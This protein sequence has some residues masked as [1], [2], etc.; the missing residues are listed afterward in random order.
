[1]K[2]QPGRPEV[3][4]IVTAHNMEDVIDEALSSLA[5]QTWPHFHVLVV[6]DGSTDAT[7]SRI[8]AWVDRD[9]RFSMISTPGLGAGEARNVGMSA[10]TA[11]YFM[12]LDGD[13]IFRPS[14][15]E[16]LTRAA[17]K[18]NADI[19]ICNI[20]Q[21]DHK[22]RKKLRAPWAFKQC[23]LP[24]PLQGAVFSWQNIPGNIFAAFMGWPWDKL[25]RT[26]FIQEQSLLFP[27]DLSNSEDGVFTY[28]ALVRANRLTAV[29]EVLIEHR[30]ERGTSISQSR[31]R[32]PFAFYEAI[33]RLKHAFET[34]P[35]NQWENLRKPFLNWALDWTLW[36]IETMSDKEAQDLM[37]D[38]LFTNGFPALEL[39]D[40]EPAFFTGYPR[41]MARYASLIQD[42]SNAHAGP[43]GAL[44]ELPYGKYKPWSRL[45]L[46][47]KLVVYLKEKRNKPVTW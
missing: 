39:T 13:D 15:L 18:A 2:N 43:L 7:A 32:D 44:D 23:E 3:D 30:I 42:R 36:N 21:F 28:Q 6:E 31:V 38:R 10:V 4:I 40:H 37:V 29:D 17:T 47:E 22:T 34:L 25:Y 24:K 16:R 20:T 5:C 33:V 11:P 27:T 9:A 41:S 19:T 35:N 26:S 12:I 46:P 14:M 45:S 1:M 8:Q